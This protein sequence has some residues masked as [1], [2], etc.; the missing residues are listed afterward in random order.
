MAEIGPRPCRNELVPLADIDAAMAAV[1]QAWSETFGNVDFTPQDNFFALGGDSLRALGV[2]SRLRDLLGIELPAS[3][4]FSHPT[5]QSLTE[6]IVASDR[7]F[8]PTPVQA[9]SPSD[10][11]FL[12]YS[13]ERLWWLLQGAG[14]NHA[15][16]MQVAIPIEGPLGDGSL[17]QQALTI[18]VQ[19]HAILRTTFHSSER[20]PLQKV[21]PSFPVQLPVLDLSS[22]PDADQEAAVERAV[23]ALADVPLEMD[24]L[25]L[26]RWQLLRLSSTRFRLLQVEHH[27]L[28]DGW[29][30]HLLVKDLFKIHAA[31]V[32]GQAVDATTPALQFADIAALQRSYVESGAGQRQLEFWRNYLEGAPPELNFPPHRP[33][34]GVAGVHGSVHRQIIPPAISAP[35]LTICRREQATLFD[36][37]LCCFVL[38]M[39]RVS[40]QKDLVLGTG[41]ATRR[42]REMEEVPGMLVNNLALRFRLDTS[43]SFRDALRR[44]REAKLATFE[45]QDVPFDQVV[46]T[47]NPSRASNRHPL[48]QV[49]F[50]FHDSPLQELRSE[51]HR[52]EP[53]RVYNNSS[54]KFELN[55]I[56]IPAQASQR[57]GEVELIWEYNTGLFTE[58][59]IQWLADA[60]GELL[61]QLVLNPDANAFRVS[62]LNQAQRHQ[63]DQ[64]GTPSVL[65][66]REASI[67]SLFAEVVS[68]HPLATALRWDGGELAY[69]DLNKR[70]NR[71]ARLLQSFGLGHGMVAAVMLRRGPEMINL[72]LAILKCG[73]AYLALSPDD[74][75]ERLAFMLA[76]GAADLL[77]T[78]GECSSRFASA[79]PKIFTLDSIVRERESHSDSE[80]DAQTLPTD[81]TYLAYTSGSTGRPKA[82]EIPQRA[83]IRL[84][85]NSSHYHLGPSE[86]MLQ[87]APIAFDAATFEIWGALLNG[88]QLVLS[89]P[90]FQGLP[91]LA[92]CLRRYRITTLWLT[93]TLFHAMVEHELQS[94]LGVRQVLAGGEVL[95]PAAV[96]RMLQAM[97]AGHVLINGYG[98]TENTTFTCCCRLNRDS[99]IQGDV[100]IGQPIANS[101]VQILDENLQQQP[102]GVQ[103][104]LYTGGDGLALGYYQRPELTAQKFVVDPSAANSHSRLYNTGDLAMWDEEGNLHYLGRQDEQVKI[105]GFRVETAEIEF[106]ARQVDGVL[107]FVVIAVPHSGAMTLAAFLVAR[108]PQSTQALVAEHLRQVL[109]ASMQPA[110]IHCVDQLPVTSN[111]KLD[112]SQLAAW[113]R[114]M[115]ESPAAASCLPVA[116]HDKDLAQVLEL[117]R[118]IPDLESIGEDDDFFLAG[119][120]SLLAAHVSLLISRRFDVAFE[121]IDLLRSPTPRGIARTLRER[122]PRSQSRLAGFR[123]LLPVQESG[124]KPTLF[125][126]PGGN[127]EEQSMV[128]YERLLPFCGERRFV[129]VLAVEVSAPHDLPAGSIDEL[130]ERFAEDI[131]RLQPRGPYYIAGGC[132]GGVPAAATAWAL[133]RRGCDVAAVLLLDTAFP[134]LPMQLHQLLR[135]AC[136]QLRTS[137]LR[138]LDVEAAAPGSR[139]RWLYQSLSSCLPLAEIW[140]PANIPRGSLRFCLATSRWRPRRLHSAIYLVGSSTLVEKKIPA[141]WQKLTRRELHFRAVPGDHFTFMREHMEA[142]GLEWRR[143]LEHADAQHNR[144]ASQEPVIATGEPAQ[145]AAKR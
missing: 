107:G 35:L 130:A 20:G 95:S 17:L 64:W 129:A 114:Q 131:I 25:P 124:S 62:L 21:H 144:P 6:L 39:S 142:T 98:P 59:R 122:R 8:L 69:Q 31:L 45:H 89:P 16:Q 109:P 18:L 133:E 136:S 121:L 26:V 55:V 22:V 93:A 71:T 79:C 68:R 105:R 111:G 123:H 143:C 80:I 15:Y 116:E 103:G 115:P 50:S 99:R 57:Y 51:S 134:N 29:S 106:R 27:L 65:Y 117:L 74:P 72:L 75:E 49:M 40:A 66:P 112:R 12:S 2:L 119:G 44:T 60:Y 24:H 13:Q 110:T 30:L 56:A 41:V 70:A 86:V 14:T 94:L 67:A 137:L 90:G 141:R 113:A 33:A 1:L 42:W 53:P 37:M 46:R 10:R 81:R 19:R 104:F 138:R 88:A 97:P 73:A 96:E 145:R 54:A 7:P 135:N 128:F 3:A 139:R 101:S 84:V 132:N 58:A 36:G 85:R 83:V 63:L 125:F 47:L 28:H 32:A 120:H 48:F 82:A 9:P 61:Q 91:A 43:D 140:A 5:V 38:L 34:A 126:V 127:G 23:A 100:P 78:Q 87:F 4:L 11:K 102:I 76:D 77:I 92:D 108:D 118:A 52:F